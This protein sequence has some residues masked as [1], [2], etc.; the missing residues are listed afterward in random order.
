M[1]PNDATVRHTPQPM[2]VAG[3][4]TDAG[5]QE[6]ARMTGFVISSGNFKISI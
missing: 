5:E 1:L 3:V 2:D 6:A 4:D